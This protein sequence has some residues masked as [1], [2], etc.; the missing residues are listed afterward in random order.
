MRSILTRRDFLARAAY[1]AALLSVVKPQ[2]RRASPGRMYVSLNSSLTRQMPWPDFV[3]L[4]GK[5][6]YGGVDVNLNPAKAA[7]VE[8]T[9]ALLAEL[10]L[11]P[12]VTGLPLQFAMPDEAAFQEALKQLDENAKFAAAIGCTRMMAVLSPGSQTPREERRKFVKDRLTAISEILQRSNIRLGL[13][14]LGPLYMRTGARAPYQFLY[15]LDETVGLAKECGP[16]VGVVLDAWHWFHSGGTTADILDAG[17]SRIVHIHV[18]DAKPA[19]PEEVRDNHRFMPG[20]GV[21]DLVGFFQALQKIGYEDGVSP[22]PLGR[23]PAEMPPE[24]GAR[25]GLE[26]TLAVMK[27][28][29]VIAGG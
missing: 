12:A 5:L 19:A 15:R 6:G 21:I 20:E 18:S 17:K 4:A 24:E 26:T 11:E 9:R 3:R 7:G 29:G 23:V 13:E 14:F 10:K 2:A 1:T 28:A 25:L 22:E 8:A 16:N 27:K